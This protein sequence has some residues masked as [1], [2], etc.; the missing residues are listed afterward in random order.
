MVLSIEQRIFINAQRLSE[1]TE[2]VILVEFA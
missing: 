2:Y 1:R